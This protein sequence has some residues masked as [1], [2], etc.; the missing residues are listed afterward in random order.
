MDNNKPL[1]DQKSESTEQEK[2]ESEHIHPHQKAFFVVIVALG[3]LFL[4]ALFTISMYIIG[5]RVNTLRQNQ[6]NISV[7]PMPTPTTDPTANWQTY[8]NNI[9]TFQYPNS[10]CIKESEQDYLLIYNLPCENPLI[11]GQ[12]GASF[13]I[14]TRLTGIYADYNLSLEKTKGSLYFNS[15]TNVQNGVRITGTSK[16]TSEP[17]TKP[18]PDFQTVVVLLKYKNGAIKIEKPVFIDSSGL[19]KDNLSNQSSIQFNQ[20]LSTF[21][22]TN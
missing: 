8:T 19:N 21:K 18:N 15:V 3:I 10:Y 2:T 1:Q 13:T 17:P 22:F 7:S 20:I 5:S 9:F 6:K 4:S 12:Y 16:I 11:Q 14:D